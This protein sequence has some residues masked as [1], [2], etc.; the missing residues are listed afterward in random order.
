MRVLK[1]TFISLDDA[2]K[3]LHPQVDLTYGV[4]INNRFRDREAIKRIEEVLGP[5]ASG[6]IVS[7]REYNSS[8]FGALRTEKLIMM[9]V[10]WICVQLTKMPI[11]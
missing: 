2:S 9:I 5:S 10:R 6:S 8:F 3:F 7:W 11:I 4:K 1:K